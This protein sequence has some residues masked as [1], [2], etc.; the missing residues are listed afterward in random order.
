MLYISLIA[1]IIALI[2]GRNKKEEPI[3]CEHEYERTFSTCL[4]L[5]LQCRFQAKDKKLAK[6]INVLYSICSKC[7]EELI[8]VGDG[9]DDNFFFDEELYLFRMRELRKDN[10]LKIQMKIQV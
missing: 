1:L 6:D 7:K 9:T 3:E 8:I 2:K 10:E 5:N 4:D